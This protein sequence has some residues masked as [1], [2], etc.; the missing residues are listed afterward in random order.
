MSL[1]T[2]PPCNLSASLSDVAASTRTSSPCP[3]HSFVYSPFLPQ[4]L[5]T[6]FCVLRHSSAGHIPHWLTTGQLTKRMHS[7]GISERRSI[8]KH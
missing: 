2:F 7:R 8:P 5:I 3:M 4:F 6:W 1:Q